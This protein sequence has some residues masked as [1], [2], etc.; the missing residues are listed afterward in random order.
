MVLFMFDRLRLRVDR[1]WLFRI[2]AVATGVTYMAMFLTIYL[3]C[4][5]FAQNWQVDP[6]PP[7]QCSMRMHDVWVST[8][9]NVFT[10]LMILTIPI[11][12][13]WTSRFST[14]KKI[15]LTLLLCSGLFVMSAAVI[16]F[17]FTLVGSTSVNLNKY[18]ERL[19]HTIDI[20]ADL[21]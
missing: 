10:D 5:P 11:P 18:V 8:T 21:F 12:T 1:V 16:R 14:G 20:Q 2:V 15:G 3:G 9:L 13:L 7:P 19:S 4:L 6:P 17:S